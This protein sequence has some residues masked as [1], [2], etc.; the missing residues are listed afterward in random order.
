M[1]SDAPYIET[2]VLRV[3][4]GMS[5][6]NWSMQFLADIINASV[7]RPRMLET[8]SL[9]AAWLS[10]MYTGFYPEQIEFSKNWLKDVRFD[11]KIEES[12]RDNLY[13]GWKVAV[14]RTLLK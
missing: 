8:T 7:D 9:G 5:S 2:S 13:K 14:K 1:L 10:G 6:S 3:D 4:G 12:I 11:P